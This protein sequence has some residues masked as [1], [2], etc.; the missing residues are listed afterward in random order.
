M[1]I[2]I[3]L[4]RNGTKCISL[5]QINYR[6]IDFWSQLNNSGTKE[7]EGV[8]ESSNFEQIKLIRSLCLTPAK[9]F[10]LQF[11]YS[12]RDFIEKK[13]KESASFDDPK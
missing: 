7:H 1:Y 10:F 8:I 13:R 12:K 2:K 4:F 5:N 11:Q 6:R 3:F 9:Q